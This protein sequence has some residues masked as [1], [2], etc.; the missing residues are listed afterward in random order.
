MTTKERLRIAYNTLN[1]LKFPSID[2]EGEPA[3]W[4]GQQVQEWIDNV[5]YE[6][7]EAM[8]KEDS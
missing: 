2:I 4:T 1:E 7:K 5:A 3:K 6:I 8:E